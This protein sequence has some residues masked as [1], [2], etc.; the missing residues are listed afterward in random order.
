MRSFTYS[1]RGDLSVSE[2]YR[3]MKGMVDSLRDLDKPFADRTLVL[4]LL[5]GLSPHY[6]H[7]K[8]LIKRIV[9]FLTFHVV[10]NE[11]LLEELTTETDTCSCP[12]PLYRAYRWSGAL[13]EPGPSP[14]VHRGSYPPSP[15]VHAAPR[16]AP[17]ADGGRRS[18]KGGHRSGDSTWGGPS[19]QGGGPA[20]PS[21]YNPTTS[22]R[23]Y[24]PATALGGAPLCGCAK[25][26]W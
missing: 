7:L 4:N 22:S 8:A 12:G 6:D 19:D 25:E 13:E 5:C 15:T 24:R 20:W 16:P 3:Q 23:G 2:Y 18:R 11:L 26:E 14:F 9:P 17:T 1:L 10:H 21:F